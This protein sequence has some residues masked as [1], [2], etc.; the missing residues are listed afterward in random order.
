MHVK[1]KLFSLGWIDCS[2]YDPLSEGEV[3]KITRRERYQQRLRQLG[4]EYQQTIVAVSLLKNEEEKGFQIQEADGLRWKDLHKKGDVLAWLEHRRW[5]AFGRTMGYRATDCTEENLVLTKTHKNMPLK[6]HPCLVEAEYPAEGGYQRIPDPSKC[7]ASH[8]AFVEGVCRGEIAAD[9]LDRL[10]CRWEKLVKDYGK[11][12]PEKKKE[13]P[14][15]YDFKIY[16]FCMH[17]FEEYTMKSTFD[18]FNRRE[19]GRRRIPALSEG[20]LEALLSREG[21]EIGAIA[22]LIGGRKEWLI[23]KGYLLSR[24]EKLCKKPPMDQ[25]QRHN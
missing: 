13:L 8:E 16:D 19:D 17:E 1:Y 18:R 20:R 10:S 4:R 7:Q 22:Y 5:C 6:L 25:A 23:P 21:E 15:P 14:T 11:K 12:H 9:P 2:P 3:G 24:I